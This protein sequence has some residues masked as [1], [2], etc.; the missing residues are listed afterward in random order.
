[1][2]RSLHCAL[3]AA[4]LGALFHVDAA[5]SEPP[6]ATVHWSSGYATGV[7]QNRHIQKVETRWGADYRIGPPLSLGLE[8]AVVRFVGVRDER[9]V[10]CLGVTLLPVVAWHFWRMDDAS[11]AFDLGL[12]GAVFLPS[13]PPGGTAVSGYWALGLSARLPLRRDIALLF[14]VRVMHHSSGRGFDGVAFN[15][16]TGFGVGR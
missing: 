10:N 13:F 14:G 2:R 11:L 4:L 12:G 16:G 7:D 6:R 8:A 15:L 3:A 9:R 5:A 1:M